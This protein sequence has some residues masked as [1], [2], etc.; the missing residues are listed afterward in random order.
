MFRLLGLGLRALLALVPAL[1]VAVGVFAL[2]LYQTYRDGLPVVD[3]ASQYDPPAITRFVAADGSIIGEF[4]EQRRIVVPYRRIPRQL[5]QAF[6]AAEDTAFF[7]HDGID[8][9]GVVRAALINLRAGRVRQGASTITQQL[10]K[11]MLVRKIGYAKGTEALLGRKIREAG[12]WLT[13]SKEDILTSLTEIYLGAG[14]TVSK[15]CRELLL[16]TRRSEKAGLPPAPRYS[17]TVQ[18]RRSNRRTSYAVW[19]KRAICTTRRKPPSQ[20]PNRTSRAKR[21]SGRG[22]YFTEPFATSSKT[23]GGDRA[24]G[25]AD[26]DDH[27]RLER[28]PCSALGGL[29]RLT[30]AWYRADR[31]RRFKVSI[32][33]AKAYQGPSLLDR[34]RST[35]STSPWSSVSGACEVLI[36]SKRY[37]V[38]LKST[39]GCAPPAGMR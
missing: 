14:F 28:P 32:A 11:Q 18:G 33:A 12:R 37:P 3:D 24:Q 31:P 23:Q 17:P 7:E 19:W 34:P 21:T 13:L 39:G 10:A 35:A 38:L 9:K 29:D 8:P 25:M 22:P 2:G 5:I 36:G 15:L 1:S 27:R 26:R 6:L 4:A 20:Q 30:G 16:R